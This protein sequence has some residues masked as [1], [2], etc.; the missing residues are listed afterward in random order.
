MS[1][2]I[3]ETI[4]EAEELIENLDKMAKDKMN[5]A[6]QKIKK[7]IVQGAIWVLVTVAIYFI[8]GTT[9]F[10]WLSLALNI[11]TA[12]AMLFAK[13]MVA[14]AK[15]R[16]VERDNIDDEQEDDIITTIEPK[17]FGKHE[18]SYDDGLDFEVRSVELNGRTTQLRGTIFD[19]LNE[20][21]VQKAVTLLDNLEVLDAK[22]RKK[23]MELL[24]EEDEEVCSYIDIHH[25]EYGDEVRD[26]VFKKLKVEKQDN[27]AFIKNLELGS[28]HITEGD[29]EDSVEIVM[30]YSLIW[31]NGT[32]FT[33]QVLAMHFN[34]MLAYEMHTHDS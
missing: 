1:K 16:M 10:F 15:K 4:T 3:D 20:L 27:R 6:E 23:W 14:K 12:G 30:D 13:V 24:E 33:D 9:W 25:D 17:L 11:M 2:D 34:D 7:G 19:A 5:E 31:E 21:E 8:W 29:E 26:L 28:F 18:Y 32:S 22:A